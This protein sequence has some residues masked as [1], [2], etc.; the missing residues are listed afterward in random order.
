MG[1]SVFYSWQS[2][3][4]DKCNRR[5]IREALEAAVA[6]IGKDAEVLDAPRVESGMEGV[7]GT[8]EVAKTMFDKID[9]SDLFLGDLTLVGSIGPLEEGKANKPTPNP[10]V[11][12]ELGYAAARMG[13]ERIICVMNEHF[14]PRDGL[15]FDVRS[16]RHPIDYTLDPSAMED[17]KNAQKEL[18]KWIK[19][20]IETH[21]EYEHEA[22][23]SAIARLDVLC[24]IVCSVYLRVPYFRD[25]G[26]DEPNRTALAPVLDTMSFR[27]A[28]HRLLD[29]GLITTDAHSKLYAYHWSYRGK[30]VLKD[31]AK[32]NELLPVREKYKV[33]FSEAE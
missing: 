1:I 29:L 31:L 17:K 25:L 22:V 5:F 16:K 33:E 9:R 21:A 8:Q 19:R 10:N 6:E 15:P 24:L 30:L 20:A 2:D 3:A 4:P 23:R 7:P 26:Q 14:G 18:A 11:M 32:R 27:L 13:W 12:A 28:I